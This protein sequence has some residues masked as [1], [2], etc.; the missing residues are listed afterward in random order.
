MADHK[1]M[2]GGGAGNSVNALSARPGVYASVQML[3]TV[4][5][6]QF[7]KS[8]GCGWLALLTSKSSP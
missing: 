6:G 3:H 8:Q 1:S 4:Y 7:A 2:E 5:A